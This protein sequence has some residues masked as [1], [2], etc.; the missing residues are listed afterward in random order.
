MTAVVTKQQWENYWANPAAPA[1]FDPEMK[2]FAQQ[3]RQRGKPGKVIMVA[4]M[5]KML[6]K[7]NAAVR[8]AL[9]SSRG[10]VAAAPAAA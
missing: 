3:L 1:R 6:V 2:A 8:D 10:T 7:L 5:H 9:N 4:V